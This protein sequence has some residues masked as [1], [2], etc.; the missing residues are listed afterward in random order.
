MSNVFSDEL[1]Q[2]G[3]KCLNLLEVQQQIIKLPIIINHMQFPWYRG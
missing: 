1:G 2:N 3:Q